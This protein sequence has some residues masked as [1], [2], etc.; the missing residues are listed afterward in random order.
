MN[1][2]VRLFA[3]PEEL[4]E[5]AAQEILRLSQ[6]A[7]AKQESFS[8]VLA[9]GNTP[10]VLYRALARSDSDSV[11][12]PRIHLFWGDERYVPPDDSQSNYRMARETL[13][14]TLPIQ[15]DNVHAMPTH[16]PD[17]EE[18]ARAYETT[19]RAYFDGPWPVFDLTLLGLGADGHTT[20]LFPGSPA[21]EEQTRWVVPAAS[22]AEL[23]IPSSPPSPPSPPSR[24]SLTL[25]A[26]NHSRNTFFLVSGTEKKKVLREI[27]RNPA[28]AATRYP[29]ARVR[30]RNPAVWFVDR[31]AFGS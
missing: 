2:T 7:L 19:L 4:G 25:P 26:L 29:A 20:S 28:Q 9:G 5:A 17:P 27:L 15:P 21:L 30:P 10:R 14:E 23:F 1:P 18:A 11:L 6:A 24:L 12:W 22:P 13:L 3:G 16:F 8:L 31:P